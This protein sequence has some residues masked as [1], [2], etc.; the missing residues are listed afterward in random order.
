MLAEPWM[1][2]TPTSRYTPLQL[3]EM[4]LKSWEDRKRSLMSQLD[5]VQRALSHAR[6]RVEELK[7]RT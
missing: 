6:D 2:R 4:D 1:N 3:A 7:R 5:S